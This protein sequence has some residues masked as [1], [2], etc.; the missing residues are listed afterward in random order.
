LMPNRE[1]MHAGAFFGFARG[2]R[3]CQVSGGCARCGCARCLE[4]LWFRV[5][6]PRIRDR[7]ATMVA[8]DRSTKAIAPDLAQLQS[9]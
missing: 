5:A 6:I 2:P 7:Q 1:K 9:S 4:P 8:D 3:L